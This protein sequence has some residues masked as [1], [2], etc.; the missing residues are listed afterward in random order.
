MGPSYGFYEEQAEN[1][2]RDPKG[3]AIRKVQIMC[4]KCKENFGGYI[5]ILW[6]Y[7]ELPDFMPI[8]NF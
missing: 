6:R 5:W 2:A 7:P 8:E 4:K 3:F 1:S